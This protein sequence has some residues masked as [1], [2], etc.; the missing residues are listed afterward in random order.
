MNT[1]ISATVIV[2]WS[3]LRLVET[4]LSVGA[5]R[6]YTP[7]VRVVSAKMPSVA[8][9]CSLISAGLRCN[10]ISDD[11]RD[12]FLRSTRIDSKAH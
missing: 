6:V 7:T 8:P 12:F 10:H 1:I 11:R 9:S 2:K 3:A 4:M 5:A